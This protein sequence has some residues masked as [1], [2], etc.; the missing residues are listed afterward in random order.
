MPRVFVERIDLT[1]DLKLYVTLR[2]ILC[3]NSVYCN[4]VKEINWWS[5]QY[6]VKFKCSNASISLYNHIWKSIKVVRVIGSYNI[7]AV[8]LYAASIR[9]NLIN[10]IE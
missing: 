10:T 3:K 9:L 8:E 7:M 4:T 6:F 5:F 2:I 1:K